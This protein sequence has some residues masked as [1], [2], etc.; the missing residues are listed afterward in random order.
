MEV[1]AFPWYQRGLWRRH[2]GSDGG[3]SRGMMRAAG[4]AAA[5]AALTAGV[6][7]AGEEPELH[8]V[9]PATRGSP[10]P[11][12]LTAKEG[13]KA[14][15]DRVVGPPLPKS[16]TAAASA[17][18]KPSAA[19]K[20]S[21]R[22]T[23]P[24]RSATAAPGKQAT[25]A[26]TASNAPG[27]YDYYY[28]DVTGGGLTGGITSGSSSALPT[29]SVP[30]APVLG[31]VSGAGSGGTVGV[32]PLRRRRGAAAILGCS[33]D[34]GWIQARST[35]FDVGPDMS[36]ANCHYPSAPTGR[37]VGAWSDQMEGFESSCGKCYE[38]RCRNADITDGYGE[39]VS[40]TNACYDEQKSVVI[41]IVDACPCRYPNNEYSNKR[42]C[43]GDQNHIDISEEAFR[44]LAD[45]NLGVIGL[46]Y[47]Q[48]D[49]STAGSPGNPNA[50]HQ[51]QPQQQ[52][53][54]QSQ[55][56]GGGGGWGGWG[57]R[58]WGWGS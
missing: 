1:E 43:C 51:S 15:L 46:Y 49:C 7:L 55:S 11:G 8:V 20:P 3:C 30:I 17:G 57:G 54:Q 56:G 2:P 58:R 33:A 10:L 6:P 52:Q 37:D 23:P 28:E 25:A 39:T 53:S 31:G 48:V 16:V 26:P 42:W 32:G 22:G 27:Y 35:W 19:A 12:S 38:I 44:Q 47:R 40:R 13:L 36:K 9:S 29:R 41:T 21:G 24:S 45:L 5:A 50:P 14:N 4:A 34:D 18:A